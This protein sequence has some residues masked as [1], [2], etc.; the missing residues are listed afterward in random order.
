MVIQL[1]VDIDTHWEIDYFDGKLLHSYFTIVSEVFL[2]LLALCDRFRCVL[3]ADSFKSN[4]F[5]AI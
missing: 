5:V 2:E 1:T 3:E 4:D